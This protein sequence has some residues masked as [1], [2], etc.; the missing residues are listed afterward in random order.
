[1]PRYFRKCFRITALD[2][3]SVRLGLL[4]QSAGINPTNEEV[5]P[6]VL[7]WEEYQHRLATWDE[8]RKKVGLEAEFY[9]GADVLLFPKVWLDHSH[10]LAEK[11]RRSFPRRIA[12]AMGID[13]AEGGDHTSFAIID[14]LGLIK[15]ITERTPNTN[16]IYETACRLL[17]EYRIPP[18]NVC[19]DRGGGGKQHADRMNAAGFHGVRS[20]GFGETVSAEPMSGTKSVKRRVDEQGERYTY[21]NRRAEMYWNLSQRMDPDGEFGGFAIEQA[22]SVGAELRRQLAPFPKRYDEESRIYL[23]PKNRKPGSK[24]GQPTLTEIIGRSPDDAD[25]LVLALYA[26]THKPAMIRHTVGLAS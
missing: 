9:E 11:F 7:T 19:F 21:R 1:M 3:P 18:E 20:V 26:M 23:P 2:S 10:T 25:A 8:I 16:A 6:G 24:G 15:L 13:P 17:R 5:V 22:S 12:R 14:D 4:Q